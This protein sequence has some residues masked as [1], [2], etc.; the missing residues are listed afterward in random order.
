MDDR[1]IGARS[2]TTASD[3]SL[4]PMLAVGPTSLS[5]GYRELFPRGLRDQ[6]INL[7]T[8]QPTHAEI[9]NA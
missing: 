3:F 9:N 8:G 2:P 6:G 7:T 4:L 1:L 5:H